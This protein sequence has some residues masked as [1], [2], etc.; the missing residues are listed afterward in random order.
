MVSYKAPESLFFGVLKGHKKS[1]VLWR[2]VMK[3]R[4]YITN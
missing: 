3:I 4:G 2:L 1:R